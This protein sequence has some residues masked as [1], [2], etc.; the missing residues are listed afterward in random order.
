MMSAHNHENAS[1]IIT[2]IGRG[3]VFGT[4]LVSVD[5]VEEETLFVKIGRKTLHFRWP[6]PGYNWAVTG[7]A[8]EDKQ[9]IP[10]LLHPFFFRE[11]LSYGGSLPAWLLGRMI[12][13]CYTEISS[14]K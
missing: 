9:F 3:V 6:F 11:Q 2:K 12:Q 14:M 8:E 13:G 7:H 1:L 5:T 4:C 10:R